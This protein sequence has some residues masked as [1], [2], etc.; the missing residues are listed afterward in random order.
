MA[1][2]KST[3]VA[4]A[5]PKGGALVSGSQQEALDKLRA[6]LLAPT[7]DKIKISNK[8]FKLP[9]GDTL[10]FLDVVVIDFIFYNV[11]YE[12]AFDANNIMPPNCFSLSQESKT[13]VPSANAP[14][15]QNPDC[16]SCWANQFASAGKGKACQ[17]RC[18]LAVLPSDANEDT[19]FSILDISPTAVKGFSS[20]MSGV[21]RGGKMP[22]EVVTHVECNPAVKHDVAV[23][24][25]PQ[26]IEDDA[27]LGMV[28]SR[29]G[30]AAERLAT[31][32]DVSA[33]KAAND[34][35]KKGS[36]KAPVKRRA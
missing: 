12:G 19:P 25:D 32:P 1:T 11:Y 9:S 33:F 6:R 7:G 15:S 16:A 17:N 36:L 2:A 24:S 26:I 27:F 35:P 13:A 30:E 10:D 28:E 3:A 21:A 20:Y 14:D 5:K 18:L 34:A 8:Q 29:L 23:F 31:E 22:Y 4:K